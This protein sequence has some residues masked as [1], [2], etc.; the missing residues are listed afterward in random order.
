MEA[1][2]NVNV[3]VSL[4]EATI[5]RIR[6]IF[7]PRPAGIEARPALGPRPAVPEKPEGT[8]S[9]DQVGP[10]PESAPAPAP[11]AP[12]APEIDNMTLNTAVKAAQGRGV[13]ADAIRTVF[14]K[15]GI[16]SSREC[17]ADKRPALL[18]ELNA[19]QPDLPEAF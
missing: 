3:T 2:V 14:A 17:P 7:A 8:K 10:K 19:M 15:Y 11:E 1:T 18:A 13:E 4:E 16:K 6:E 5:Q 12:K 9:G